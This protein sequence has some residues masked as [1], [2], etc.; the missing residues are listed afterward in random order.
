MSAIHGNGAR[1]SSSLD[2]WNL[3]VLISDISSEYIYIWYNL[4]TF[5][6]G[7]FLLTFSLAFYLAFF[8]P[9]NLAYVLVCYLAFYLTFYSGILSGIYSD[10]LFWHSISDIFGYF[11]WWRSG[12]EHFDPELAVQVRRGA[13]WSGACGGGPAGILSLRWR[14]GGEHSDPELAVEVRRGT[15]RS[16]ASGGE[17]CDLELAVEVHGRKEEERGGAGWHNNN[18]HLTGGEQIATL[19]MVIL[20]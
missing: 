9:K 19:T 13:L 3:S 10:I 16:R 1:N 12:G 4:L 18:P 8:L 5:Y 17:R 14:S 20:V 7:I 2:P 11:L 6:S 15:L